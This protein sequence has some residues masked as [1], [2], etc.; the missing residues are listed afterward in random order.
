MWMAKNSNDWSSNKLV[1]IVVVV[2][3]VVVI[4]VLEEPRSLGSND[5]ILGKIFKAVRIML[6][7]PNALL[8]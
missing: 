4:A 8:K 7:I 2:V 3:V 1:G 5:C 6:Y